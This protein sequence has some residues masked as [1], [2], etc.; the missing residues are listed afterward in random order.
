MGVYA[1]TAHSGF[2]VQSSLNPADSY[3]NLLVQGF[4]AGQLNL[5]TDV[6]PGLAQLANPYDP[7]A[8]DP[9]R[10]LD[11]SYYRGKLYLYFGVTPVV[12]LFWPY[13]VTTG[14]YLLQKDAAVA[15]CVV[16]FLASVGLLCAVWRR[17]FAEVSVW[18]VAAGALALGLVTCAPSLL[19]RSDVWEVSIGCGYAFTMLAL[20]GI[21]KALHDRERRCWWLATASL[22]YGL[23]VGA[24]PSLLFGAAALLLPV[25]HAWRERQRVWTPLIAAIGPIALIGLGL[26]VYNALRFDNPFEF[27]YRYGLFLDRLNTDPVFSWRYLWFHFR[28]YFLEPARWSGRFPFVRGITVPPL[29]AGHGMPEHPFGVLT[30][31]PIVWLALAVPLAWRCRPADTRSTLFEFLAAVAILFGT[32]A[33]TL[34]LYFSASIRYEFEFLS[35]LVLLAVIGILSLERTLV[36]QR[37]R[38]NAMRW[39]WSL[40]LGFSVAF[41][42][43]A[44]VERCAESVNNLGRALYEAGRIREAMARF[45]QALRLTPDFAEVHNGLGLALMAQ[46]RVREAIGH[47]EQALR[48]T[49]DFA[50]AHYNLGIAMVGQGRLQEAIGQFEQ[51]V[52]LKPDFADAHNDLGFALMSQGRLQGAMS[53]FEQALRLKPDLAEAHYNLGLALV[54]QGRLQDAIAQWEQALRIKPDL[55]KAHYNLGV[56]LYQLGRKQEAIGHWEQALRIKPDY[57][58]ARSNLERARAAR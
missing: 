21:W 20:A 18:V 23:A 56:A 1:Y 10:V 53:H 57:T 46:G 36:H 32:S 48:L 11:M 16:G 39:G 35:A 29:P 40:L 55:A 42:L 25:V 3:Y 33:L 31:I 26:M 52:S 17:H 54:G 2:V 6:P 14:N 8:H 49:P 51:A 13:A 4:R 44:S 15:F 27:G 50:E 28:V 43:F 37:L 58:E 30:N 41:N 7:V 24:R 9:Y 19:A 47:F 22:A 34:S 45:E 5:K 38:R 12:L